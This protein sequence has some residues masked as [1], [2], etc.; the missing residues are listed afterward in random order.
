MNNDKKINDL[1]GD[2]VVD[3]VNANSTD[4]ACLS[5]IP[6]I[7][8][9]YQFSPNFSK[10]AQSRFPSI[11]HIR[12]DLS[13]LQRQIVDL[14]IQYWTES[15]LIEEAVWNLCLLFDDYDLKDDRLILQEEITG[16]KVHIPLKDINKNYQKIEKKIIDSCHDKTLIESWKNTLQGFELKFHLSNIRRYAESFIK[17]TCDISIKQQNEMEILLENGLLTAHRFVHYK[18]AVIKLVISRALNGIRL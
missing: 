16:K 1:C 6:K 7:Q 14:H 11:E 10:Y 9:Y 15:A 12:N 18:H 8:E 17:A 5:L 2:A 13:P 3:F 4:E